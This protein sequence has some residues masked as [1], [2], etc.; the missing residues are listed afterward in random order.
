[1][2]IETIL[3]ALELHHKEHLARVPVLVAEELGTISPP[4]D[5]MNMDVRNT[6]SPFFRL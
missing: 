4:L 3:L 6:S 1:M 2:T 5:A